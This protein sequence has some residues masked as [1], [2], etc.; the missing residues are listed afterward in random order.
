MTPGVSIQL[1]GLDGV[2]DLLRSL[3]AEVVSKNGGPVRSA[4]RH[5]ALVI[6]AEHKARL[7]V[8]LAN[9]TDEGKLWSTGLLMSNIIGRRGKVKSGEKFVVGIRGQVYKR[10]GNG[11]PINTRRTAQ[12]LEYGNSSQPAE[13]WIR[14]SFAAKAPE[15]IATIERTLVAEL[16]RVVKRLALKAKAR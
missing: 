14:P 2:Y 8:V 4:L 3:P 12:M 9:T 10:P 15:A 7:A 6:M 11:K 13:P 1:T 5:G 16:D